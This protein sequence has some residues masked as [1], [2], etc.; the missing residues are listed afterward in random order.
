MKNVTDN[1]VVLHRP[2][3]DFPVNAQAPT[4]EAMAQT[5]ARPC[6]KPIPDRHKELQFAV[7]VGRTRVLRKP[8]VPATRLRM[9]MEGVKAQSHSSQNGGSCHSG[10]RG[11]CSLAHVKL[12]AEGRKWPRSGW[13]DAHFIRYENAQEI[14]GLAKFIDLQRT[15]RFWL[16]VLKFQKSNYQ[17]DHFELFQAQLPQEVLSSID[18][19][20]FSSPKEKEKDCFHLNEGWFLAEWF[21]FGK[22]FSSFFS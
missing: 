16:L 22:I 4:I 6:R 14:I 1:S 20:D 19:K 18:L 10:W 5:A 3:S 2:F 11:G 7:A 13:L 8:V 15:E 12:V 17:K 21:T 9:E